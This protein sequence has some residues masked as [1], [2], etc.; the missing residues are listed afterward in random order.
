MRIESTL[1][2]AAVTILSASTLSW[3]LPRAWQPDP[4]EAL[5]G[6]LAVL[7]ILAISLIAVGIMERSKG[8]KQDGE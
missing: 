1:T 3:L 2:V 5:A 8:Q 7:G 4:G 6:I